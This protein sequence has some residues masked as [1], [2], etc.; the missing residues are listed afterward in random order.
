MRYR[1]VSDALTLALGADHPNTLASRH[2]LAES[3]TESRDFAEAE[4]IVMDTLA[5][6]RR[7]LGPDHPSTALSIEAT[8]RLMVRM[9]HWADAQQYQRE[10]LAI[11]LRTL[12]PDNAR[13]LNARGDLALV[14][15]KS[16]QLELAEE[17]SLEALS[18]FRRV[19]GPDH[20]RVI[21]LRQY[22]TKILMTCGK[23]EEAAA[24]FADMLP[25][26]REQYAESSLFPGTLGQASSTLIGLGRG[27]EAADL[28]RELLAWCI[29]HKLQPTVVAK[30][31]VW[32]ARA[33]YAQDRLVEA[34][35][36][37]A[38]AMGLYGDSSDG[39]MGLHIARLMRHT[40]AAR[41]GDAGRLSVAGQE[42]RRI[43]ALQLKP[44]DRAMLIPEMRRILLGAGIDVSAIKVSPPP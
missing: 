4:P 11:L 44:E 35:A 6:R 40:I 13:T 23:L 20:R 33:L 36:E 32:L 21:S 15:H 10:A 38:L 18:E 28:S 24:H 26:C 27:A 19:L 37:L 17:V 16:G 8:M 5:R 41:A 7:V 12:G 1:R 42:Y 29:D 3:L 9:G 22:H 31:H 25:V 2:G 34:E 39:A 14:L 30:A 43:L